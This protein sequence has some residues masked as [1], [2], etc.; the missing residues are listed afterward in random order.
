MD[1]QIRDA[2]QHFARVVEETRP[3]IV[4]AERDA[5]KVVE[6]IVATCPEG[7]E[8]K[9]AGH[10]NPHKHPR[11]PALDHFDD[12]TYYDWVEYA[13]KDG[14]IVDKEGLPVDSSA[15]AAEAFLRDCRNG[16]IGL[17]AQHVE[18]YMRRSGL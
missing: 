14:A 5:A 12:R 6:R 11:N 13:I 8:L 18:D 17:I 15:T 1:K 7:V 10:V 9:I 4:A 2:L 16:L 3:D